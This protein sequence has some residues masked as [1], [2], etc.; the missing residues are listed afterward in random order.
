M[1]YFAT[2]FKIKGHTFKE[3]VDTWFLAHPKLV[4]MANKAK[5]ALNTNMATKQVV[6][7]DD[8]SFNATKWKNENEEITKKENEQLVNVIKKNN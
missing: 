7:S 4:E 2:D 6:G 5:E 3:H 8:D 1:M